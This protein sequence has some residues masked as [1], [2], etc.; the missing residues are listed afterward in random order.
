MTTQSIQNILAM[1]SLNLILDT[2]DSKLNHPVGAFEIDSSNMSRWDEFSLTNISGVFGHILCQPSSM[3][4][5][6][7]T[8][9]TDRLCGRLSDLQYY[10]FKPLLTTVESL[11]TEGARLLGQRL[12]PPTVISSIQ[13]APLIAQG[14][15]G[16]LR[17]SLA[18][19]VDTQPRVN[20]LVG[21]VQ[22]SGAWSSNDLEA[23]TSR[24]MWPIER[25]ARY[26]KYG[27]TR[28]SFIMT[29]VELVVVY[30]FRMTSGKFGAQWQ[31]IPR[32]ACGEGT[33]TVSL[34]IWSLVMMSLN[35]EHRAVAGQLDT[36][37]INIWWKQG[38]AE[39]GF[40]YQHHLSG[41]QLPFLPMGAVGVDKKA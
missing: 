23:Q 2:N 4:I 38:N 14:G 34:A 21:C 6:P 1:P 12:G 15:S 39:S 18:F 26:A 9:V 11:M 3:N 33:M 19:F 16:G 29:D 41:R 31:A 28:Y 7:G 5:D 10:A 13:N 24:A 32:S 27:G 17:P 8:L 20:L 35:R 37:P 36:L 40:V 25:L 22:L 30:F